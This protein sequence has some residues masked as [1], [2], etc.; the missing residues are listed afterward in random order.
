M[1]DEGR[2]A[3]ITLGSNNI[4]RWGDAGET[5]Q[6]A[7][8]ALSGLAQTGF[9]RSHFYQTPAFP[10]GAGPDFVNAAVVFR[11]QM[12]GTDLLD[13]LHEIEAQAGRERTQRWGPRTLDLDLVALADKVCPDTT[14]QR[15][16]M[17]LPADAQ[18]VETPNQLILPHPRVQDRSFALVPLA[19]VAPDWTHPVLDR[20]ILE[21][22]KALPQSDIDNV[23]KL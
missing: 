3:L 18:M 22:R 9:K 21:M 6:K 8:I 23:V 5:V 17:D 19:D 1:A 7:M 11:T 13:K 4:S 12:S 16:W 15:H 20:T 2:L 10:T 14:T